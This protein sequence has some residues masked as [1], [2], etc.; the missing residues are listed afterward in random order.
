MLNEA[1]KGSGIRVKINDIRKILCFIKPIVKDCYFYVILILVLIHL[2]CINIIILIY[3]VLIYS[4][5]IGM[6]QKDCILS[7]LLPV[8]IWKSLF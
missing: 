6:E 4:Y 5:F 7:E 1:I 2:S 8:D 3:L